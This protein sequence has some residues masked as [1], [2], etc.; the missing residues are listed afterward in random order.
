MHAE[1]ILSVNGPIPGPSDNLIGELEIVYKD[2]HGHPEL[3]M[4][5]QRTAGIAGAWLERFGYEVTRDVGGTGVVGILRNGDGPTVLLRADMDALPMQETTG[6]V[7]ASKAKGVDRFGQDSFI[8]HSCGHDMHVTWLIGAARILAENKEGWSGTVMAV[9]QP[10]EETGQG[11]RAMIEDQMVHRFPKPVVALGQHLSPD[12]AGTIGWRAGPVMSASDSWEVK[13]FGRGA[14]G[15]MPEKS[16]DPI[17]MAAS[18]VL[19][20]Q[21][22]VSR[23]VGMQ[24]QAVVTVGSLHSGTSDNIIPEDALMRLNVRSFNEEVRGRVLE[25]IRRI[26][27]AE[28]IGAG[29]DRE[30]AISVLGEH[31]LTRNDETTTRRLAEVFSKRF[32][33]DQVHEMPPATASE[34]FG[35]FGA[36]WGI[37]SVFWFVG[38]T[39]PS[40]LK[41]AEENHTQ[42]PVNHNPAFAPTL[43]PT[44]SIGVQTLLIAASLWLVPEPAAT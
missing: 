26:L 3:S 14:H 7:Y 31:P 41:A 22:V 13:I 34:D 29:A 15:S 25:G 19:N 38:G 11:A 21:T 33:D 1:S 36:A 16:I 10:G 12:P 20:L 32:G 4:Q 40:V 37:P 17:V 42:I 27:K 23:E 39:D 18:A 43:H 5:E 35:L 24:E 8:A 30:P 44:I 6:L 28:A 2:I 9:F